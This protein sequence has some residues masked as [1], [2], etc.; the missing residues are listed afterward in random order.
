MR[1]SSLLV[2]AL[3]G[4]AH[5]APAPMPK[6]VRGP[7]YAPVLLRGYLPQDRVPV[8]EP[9]VIARQADW[10]TV[11]KAWGIQGPPKVNFRTHFLFVHV[12]VAPGHAVCAVDGAGDLRA[13]TRYAD[14]T[15]YGGGFAISG[16]PGH[17]YLIQSFPRSA[18]KTVNGSPLPK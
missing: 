6:P 7:E 16:R 18:V 11:A 13:V 9:A 3:A 17:R 14:P 4:L 10:E 5:A 2:L 12:W 8:G 1:A 15:H